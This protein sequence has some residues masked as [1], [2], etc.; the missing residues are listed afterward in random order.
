VNDST[1]IYDFNPGFGPAVSSVDSG[2]GF[3][4]RVFWTAVIPDSDVQINPGAGTAALRV[5]DLPEVNYV[6]PTGGAG[7]VSLGPDWQTAGIDSTVSIDVVWNGPVTRRAHVKDQTYGF[8]G[9]FNEENQ[10][11][12]TWSAENAAGFRFTSDVGN[13]ATSNALAPGSFFAQLAHERNGRFFPAGEPVLA[14]ANPQRP[15]RQVL[16]AQQLQ[17]VLRDAVAAWQ[18][19]GASPAQLAALDRAPVHIAA[20]PSRYLGEEAGGQVWVSPNADGWGWS[21]ST[22]PAHGRMDLL[23]VLT[24][25]LGH[26]LGL[27]DSTNGRDV[28]GEALPPGVRRLPTANDLPGMTH[29]VPSDAL[30]VRALGPAGAPVFGVW[31][32]QSATSGAGASAPVVPPAAVGPAVQL[33]P[34]PA[35]VTV[36]PAPRRVRDQVFADLDGGGLAAALW[37]SEPVA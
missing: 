24:H 32:V 22:T 20:L 29:A 15:V 18:D 33:V 8:T 19:A 5:R 2:N 10:V 6:S 12:V 1:Q 14:S 35:V 23:S 26:V 4:T 36:G 7:T 13:F 31:P 3:G 21:M 30:L 27:A 11:S 9:T 25:E 17:P 37:P 28:M 16:T 34:A